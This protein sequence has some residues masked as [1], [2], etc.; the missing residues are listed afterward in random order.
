[1]RAMRANVPNPTRTSGQT[2]Q[3]AD[4]YLIRWFQSAQR[5]ATLGHKTVTTYNDFGFEVIGMRGS[6]ELQPTY[7]GCD[8]QL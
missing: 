6:A 3:S 4:F 5:M 8:H 1:M 2:P 7:M